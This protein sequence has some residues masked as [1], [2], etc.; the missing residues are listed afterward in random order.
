M[1]IMIKTTQQIKEI[2]FQT[3]AAILECAILLNLL[4][5]KHFMLIIN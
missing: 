1:S 2:Q 5:I 4:F 3:V